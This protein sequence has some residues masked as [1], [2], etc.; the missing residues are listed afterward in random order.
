[1]AE[2]AQ[3]TDPELWEKVKKQGGGYKSA[4]SFDNY[5]TE[6]TEEARGQKRGRR[7]SKDE[8]DRIQ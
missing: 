3:K 4:K 1:M 5:L 8:E 6:W 2:T 7:P